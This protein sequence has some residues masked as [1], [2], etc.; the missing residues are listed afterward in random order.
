VEIVLASAALRRLWPLSGDPSK[1]VF[2]RITL[3]DDQVDLLRSVLARAYEKRQRF[4]LRLLQALRDYIGP[5]TLRKPI[6]ESLNITKRKT[7]TA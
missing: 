5:R 7:D 2:R 4:P 6:I 3:S 1:N